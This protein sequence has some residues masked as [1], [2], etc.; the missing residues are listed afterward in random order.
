M[1][2]SKEKNLRASAFTML[3]HILFCGICIMQCTNVCV[4]SNY[5]LVKMYYFCLVNYESHNGIC[6]YC[7]ITHFET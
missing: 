6:H 2:N 7:I 1:I 5:T 3:S 4:C